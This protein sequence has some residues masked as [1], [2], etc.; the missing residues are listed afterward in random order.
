MSGKDLVLQL[1]LKMLPTNKIIVYFDHPYVWKEW[2]DLIHFQCGDNHQ[3]KEGSVWDYRFCL[4]VTSCTPCSIRLQNS[5][6]I[7]ILDFLHEDSYKEKLLI[8]FVCGHIF[9]WYFKHQNHVPF[10]LFMFLFFFNSAL[11]VSWSFFKYILDRSIKWCQFC[12]CFIFCSR[13]N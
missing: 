2:N 4:G 3:R 10:C 8:L 7:N 12:K 13:M 1:W 5:L 9:Y 11:I 6:I